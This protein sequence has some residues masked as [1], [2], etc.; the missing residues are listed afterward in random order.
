MEDRDQNPR[1]A[2]NEQAP[3][4]DNGGGGGGSRFGRLA[5][6]LVALI[7][8]LLA[9]P[10]ACQ[11]FRGGGSDSGSTGDDNSADSGNSA[12]QTSEDGAGASG[13][14]TSGGASGSE[15][16]SALES[17]MQAAVGS[18]DT[19]AGEGTT[20]S[21]TASPGES[22]EG[23]SPEAEIAGL[24]AGQLTGQASDGT[25]VT[26]AS[27]SLSG[28]AGWISV[29]G[30]DPDGEPG[31]VIGYAPL[32]EGENDN[33]IVSLDQPVDGSGELYV[34]V[35]E[36]APSD[37][38]F[39]YPEGD[40]TAETAAG[41]PATEM[42]SYDLTEGIADDSVAD[43]G[44]N[45]P[46]TTAAGGVEIDTLPDSGGVFNPGPYLILTLGAAM[47]ALGVALR[48]KLGHGHE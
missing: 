6:I 9:I 13:E 8:L 11:A 38:T 14:S 29:L 37:D 10:F 45:T 35:H 7:L 47:L 20:V 22:G 39:S 12:E 44:E 5:I 16:G 23:D 34:S 17:T 4:V 27:A 28:A 30:A 18:G 15:G 1:D 32:A 2:T 21:S 42:V 31:E 3:P 48:A 19:D 36:D 40:P 41:E 25:S 46:E 24:S 43:A 26:V 33:V